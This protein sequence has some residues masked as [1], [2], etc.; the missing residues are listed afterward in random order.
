VRHPDP[1]AERIGLDPVQVTFNLS[2]LCHL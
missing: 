1:G 2:F